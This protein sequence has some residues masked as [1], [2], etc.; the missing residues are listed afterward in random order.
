ME[1]KIERKK[2]N[3]LLG[4]TEVEGSLTF[5]GPTPSYKD[6]TASLSTSLKVA[7]EVV[8]LQHV[9]T[10]FGV[11]TAKF[12][13]LVYDSKEKLENVEGKRVKKKVEKPAEAAAA[14]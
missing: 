13:A 4:R 6:L 12:D 5:T 11:Q 3:K 8:L 1:V 2:E 9:Y 7:P 14:E 10:A